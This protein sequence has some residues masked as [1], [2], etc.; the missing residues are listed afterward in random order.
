LKLSSK[1]V[2]SA[3]VALAAIIWGSN[4]VIVNLVALD[5][6]V[7]AFFRVFFASLVLFPFVYINNRKELAKA[8]KTWKNLLMLG[9]LLSLG[10]GFLFQSM[11]LIAVAN[12]V[13]LNYLAPIFVALLAPILL[14]ERIEKITIFALAISTIGMIVLSSQSNFET[15]NFNLLGVLFGLLAGLAYAGFILLSKKVIATLSSQIVAFFAYSA[16]IIFL[17]PS[18]FGADLSLEMSSWILLLLLGI[19]NTGLAVTLYLS[20]LKR[21]KAQKAIVFTYLEPVSSVIFGFFFLAQQPTP[22]MIIGGFLIL[23]AGYSVASK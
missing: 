6:Y 4:G 10:W 18:V 3:Y 19:V 5:A 9:V 7:I 8:A 15:S 13:F 20:G 14:R 1:A 12:A 17:C 23:S 21:I 2:G 22:L 11:K 16:T